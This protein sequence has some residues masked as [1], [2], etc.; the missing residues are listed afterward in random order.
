MFRRK[1]SAEDFRAEIE[2]HLALEAD[3]LRSEGLNE[4]EARW[5]ARRDFGNVRAAQERFY[6]KGRLVWLDKLFRDV[7][8]GMRSL[9]HSPGFALTAI[10]TLALGIGANTAVFSVMN[11]VLLKSLPVSDPGRLVYLRTSNPPRGTGTI[12]T[13]QTLSYPVYDALRHQN[14]GLSPLMAYVPLSGGKVAVRYGAE[15]EEAE[16]DMVSGTFFSGLG[17]NLPLGRGFSEDDETRHAPVAVISYNYWTRRFAR[18]PDVMGKTLYVNSVPMTIV[19]IAAEG[20]EGVEPGGSTDFW[21]P[22][23]D[24]RELNA[25]GNPPQDGKLYIA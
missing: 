2:A 18:N 25:W 10:L 14:T 4:D 11:A 17:V 15:P 20:F 19:G 23:Q 5:K 3:D 21:I 1:R 12:D 7:R 24:R 16:G 6:L 22:L 9:R 8:F 13:E